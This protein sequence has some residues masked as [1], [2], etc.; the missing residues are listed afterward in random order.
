MLPAPRCISRRVRF[1]LTSK[2]SRD[3]PGRR[4]RAESNATVFQSV[5]VDARTDFRRSS[6]QKRAARKVATDSPASA[7]I[8]KELANR[9]P[10]VPAWHGRLCP[11]ASRDAPA[12]VSRLEIQPTCFGLTSLLLFDQHAEI[13]QIFLR[14]FH[15]G[16]LGARFLE[17]LLSH[18]WN[19]VLFF[20]EVV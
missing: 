17:R 4:G 1:R 11:R 18:L 3:R 12:P 16:K 6:R 19:E 2:H 10:R 15:G 13:V 14:D 8:G 20:H 9:I 7:S 5:R